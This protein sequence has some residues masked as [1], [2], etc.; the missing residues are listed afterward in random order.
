[1]RDSKGRFCKKDT[2]TPDMLAAIGDVMYSGH[3]F[4]HL[5][6]MGKLPMHATVDGYKVEEFLPGGAPVCFPFPNRPDDPLHLVTLEQAKQE[7]I[8]ETVRDQLIVNS[9]L[10]KGFLELST[11][12]EHDFSLPDKFTEPRFQI[13]EEVYVV[14]HLNMVFMQIIAFKG[15]VIG[16]M[17]EVDENAADTSATVRYAW[18]YN[19][20]WKQEANDVDIEWGEKPGS[21]IGRSHWIAED[22]I[23][24]CKEEAIDVF[25]KGAQQINQ[26]YGD[27]YTKL[28]H[29]KPSDIILREKK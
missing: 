4:G 11:W 1:M 5:D 13:G 20:Y 18:N 23:Y 8:Q 7:A 22:S 21:L 26:L 14:E 25:L 15:K 12:H 9:D 19:I 17:Y 27:I 28:Q 3:G 2:E 6:R 10:R 16:Q 24:R 29:L